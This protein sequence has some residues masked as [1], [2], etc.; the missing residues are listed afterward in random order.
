VRQ[1]IS[2]LKYII[3]CIAAL[4]SVR[5]TKIEEIPCT[6][7]KRK[8]FKQILPVGVNTGKVM[9][10]ISCMRTLFAAFKRQLKAVPRPDPHITNE[11]I[12]FSKR[13]IDKYITPH[14]YDFDY[15]FSRWMNHLTLSK[16]KKIEKVMAEYKEKRDLIRM[17]EYGLM[18]KI[19]TQQSGGKNRAIANIDDMTKY[20]MGPVCWEL[21][22]LFTEYFPGYC[23]NKSGTQ[24]E[25]FL[26][27]AYHHG[28]TTSLQG[29]GS[30]FDLSQH[31]ELREIDMY[32]YNKLVENN[33][34]WHVSQRDFQFVTNVQYRRIVPSAYVNNTKTIPFTSIIPGT[35]FSGASDTTLMNTIRMALYNHFTLY[36]AG[37]IL[38]D[39]ELLAKG[40]D[41]MVLTDS[42][43]CPKIQQ[44]YDNL[45]AAKPKGNDYASNYYRKGIGQILKF[46]KIGDFS[47]LDFCSNAVI[48]YE[49]DGIKKFRVMRRPERM[50]ELAHYSRK[51]TNMND[52]ELAQYYLDMAKALE[53]TAGEKP[54]YKNYIYAY[55]YYAK[56][57]LKRINKDESQ[58]KQKIQ[59]KNFYPHDGHRSIKNE[60]DHAEKSLAGQFSKYNMHISV[61]SRMSEHRDEIQDHYIYKF[62]FETY[63]L[64]PTMLQYH[65][66][67]LK[68]PYL[69]Y[70]IISDFI[71]KD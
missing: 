33:R 53:V 14:L 12:E 39:Y 5:N 28:F 3:K 65:Q 38:D 29:D 54:F 34:I 55:R 37:L 62:L 63:G 69:M 10:Y 46:L 71:I 25:D 50:I 16:Q 1:K 59:S 17:V 19:E 15:S 67:Q 30:G 47:T 21:E 8:M 43:L 36:K 45:W 48:P 27:S 40:D 70:D 13:M 7:A 6:C 26:N 42:S 44:S 64:T 61:Y 35:V 56:Y 58:L 9:C 18:C 32:I 20:I 31:P 52:T 57:I 22:H 68:N 66:Q 60:Y 4:E 49:I 11:F 2:N 41:F 24:L 23:G 51:A